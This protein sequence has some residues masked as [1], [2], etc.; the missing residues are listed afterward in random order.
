MPSQYT[1]ALRSS[2]CGWS[3]TGHKHLAGTHA[4]TPTLFILFPD[5]LV[6]LQGYRIPQP[7]SNNQRLDAWHSP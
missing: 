3:T 2:W 1:P 5:N 7:S 6:E 4:P